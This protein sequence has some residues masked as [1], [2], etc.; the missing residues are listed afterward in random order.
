MLGGG[1][2]GESLICIPE[3]KVAIITLFVIAPQTIICIP[4]AKVANFTLFV[5]APQTIICGGV[6][7][8]I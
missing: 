1:G 4:K 7:G 5:I 2:G 8:L 6:K 3:A